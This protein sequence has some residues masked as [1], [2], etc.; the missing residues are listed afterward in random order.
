MQK[1]KNYKVF[2]MQQKSLSEN[3]RVFRFFSRNGAPTYAA[4]VKDADLYSPLTA[5]VLVTNIEVRN[6]VIRWTEDAV[7]WLVGAR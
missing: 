6:L 4:V 3:S 1:K 5:A 7:V 2:I